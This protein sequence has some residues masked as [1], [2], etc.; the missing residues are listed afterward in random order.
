MALRFAEKLRNQK[1]TGQKNT[2][3][4]LQRCFQLSVFPC[5]LLVFQLILLSALILNSSKLEAESNGDAEI[6]WGSNSRQS[7]AKKV[8]ICRINTSS[9]RGPALDTAF[10]SG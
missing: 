2:C 3:H 9:D 5:I 6:I 1:S 7:S 10:S 8:E 4:M